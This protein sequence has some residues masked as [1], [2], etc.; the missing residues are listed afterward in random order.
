M[1][2]LKR[3]LLSSI[4]GLIIIFL[5]GS[6]LRFNNLANNPPSLNWDEVAF[7]YNAYS[8]LKTGKDEFGRSFPVYFRSLDDYKLPVYMYMTVV[9]EQVLGYNNF[10]VRFPSALF[11]SLTIIIVFF[12]CR[13]LLKN[14]YTSLLSALLLAILPWHIQFSRMAA[15]ST[16]GLFFFMTGML[17][18]FYSLRRNSIWLIFSFFSFA[19][20]QYTYLGF[21]FI[22]PILGVLLIILYRKQIFRKNIFVFITCGLIIIFNLLL[23]Y[24]SYINRNTS[25]LNGIAAITTYTPEYQQDTME[26][27]ED[28]RHGINLPRRLFHDSHIFSSINII[29]RNYLSHFSPDFLFFN[30][31]TRHYT[32]MLGLLYLWMLPFIVLG[33]FLLPKW[34]YK[35]SIV[36]LSLFLLPPLPGSFA[37]DSPNT[38]RTIALSIPFCIVA[39]LALYEIGKKLLRMNLY[40]FLVYLFFISCIIFSGTFYFYHQNKIHL[41]NEKSQE[42]QYGR[43]EMTKYILDHQKEYDKIIVSTKLQWPNVFFL[44]YSKYDPK[45]HL[46]NGGTISGGWGAEQ[47]KIENIEFHKFDF[48]QDTGGERILF[49]G[50]PSEFPKDV[51]TQSVIKYL[52]GSNAIYIVD[53]T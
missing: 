27:I 16:V 43:K 35:S 48:S 28:G 47:N 14:D 38:I 1:R 22:T 10:A 49:V 45:K 9:S 6:F 31:G 39:S 37:F 52:D 30:T 33:L 42:W 8:I 7:G 11:G 13:I 51:H 32:P 40:Y 25:R 53:K 34:Q 24:D 17:V 29:A 46:A 23:A 20:S 15:E 50:E 3:L 18:F 41:P 21:R 12:L 26:L 2:T 36:V 5:F 4:G 19:I 44:Y